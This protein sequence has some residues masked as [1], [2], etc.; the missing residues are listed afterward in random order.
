MKEMNAIYLLIVFLVY[1][2]NRKHKE[3]QK[4]VPK[5]S[6][7]D[8]I[9]ELLTKHFADVKK[10]SPYVPYLLALG[11]LY[12]GYNHTNFPKIFEHGLVLFIL[13]LFIRSIQIVNN[14]E[15]RPLIEPTFPALNIVVLLFIYNG[16][17][18]RKHMSSA[19]L[20]IVFQMMIV[21]LMNPKNT[22][23]SSM[24]DDFSLTHL[25]FYV[26]K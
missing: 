2:I 8:T 1:I 15:R 26:F 21:L 23:L 13:F 24:M 25:L 10:L 19:Y 3:Y 16:I 12:L 20:Y 14:K 5:N 7:P 11:P 22:T 17:I 9:R 4:L 6:T 18:E